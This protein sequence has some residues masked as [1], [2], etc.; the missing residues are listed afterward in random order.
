MQLHGAFVKNSP[1]WPYKLLFLNDIFWQHALRAAEVQISTLWSTKDVV[2]WHRYLNHF[3]TSVS[4]DIF[5]STPVPLKIPADTLLPRL[6][7]LKEALNPN[8]LNL[9]INREKIWL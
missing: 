8:F 6:R 9:T 4:N 5:N 2:L 1:L 3:V 7:M